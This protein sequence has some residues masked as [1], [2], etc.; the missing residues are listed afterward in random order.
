MRG[1]G[2]ASEDFASSKAGAGE[3]VERALVIVG[4]TS[5]APEVDDTP[6]WE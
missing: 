4:V 5:I 1:T 6:G 2:S 3:S